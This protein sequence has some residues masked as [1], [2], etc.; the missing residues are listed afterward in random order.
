M[1]EGITVLSLFDGISVCQQALKQLGV[2][3]RKY[4]ASEIELNPIAITRKNFPNTIQLGSVT[5][6]TNESINNDKIDL[7]IGGSPCQDLSN[8]NTGGNDGLRKGLEGKKSSLFFQY[9]RILQEIKPK[10]FILENVAS[11]DDDQRDIITSYMGVEPIMIDAA[12]VS[13]QSRKRYFWTNIPNVTI[14]SN[15]PG[16]KLT[17]RDILE[18]D[19]VPQTTYDWRLSHPQWTAMWS[20]N[21][22]KPARPL[23]SQSFGGFHK[24]T[25]KKN[26][27]FQGNK[28]FGIDG[29]SNTLL[30]SYT[31]FYMTPQGIRHLSAVECERLQSLPDNYTFGVSTSARVKGAGNGFNVNVIQHILSFANFPKIEE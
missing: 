27:P 4:Y 24:D 26:K 2:K 10:Y 6:V 20:K 5:T 12:L 25:H 19:Y 16:E 7:L 13:A 14:P 23:C 29:K 31:G 28:I 22:D 17:V 15:H 3:V 18:V 8:S 1:S 9:V 30:V 11:M 21:K